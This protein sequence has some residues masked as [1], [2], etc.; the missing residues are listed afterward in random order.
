[1]EYLIQR[2]PQITE[3]TDSLDYRGTPNGAGYQGTRNTD[4]V[5]CYI[6]VDKMV[7]KY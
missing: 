2:L 5:Q 7:F 1:M 4:H 6:D 3:K